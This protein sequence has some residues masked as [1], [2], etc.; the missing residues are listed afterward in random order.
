LVYLS[1]KYRIL[2]INLP[3]NW[4]KNMERKRL[5]DISQGNCLK[6]NSTAAI[7]KFSFVTIAAVL[8]IASPVLALPFKRGNNGPEVLNIQRCLRTLGYFTGQPNGNF[9]PGTE[10]AVIKFQQVEKILPN[11][12]VGP[13]TLG[14]LQRQCKNTSSSNVLRRGSRGAAV[15]KL[16]E[17]LRRLGLNSP[18]TDFF[19][20][21]TEQAVNRF[22]KNQGLPTDGIVD[23]KT[24]QTI[25]TALT[26]NCGRV[27]QYPSLRLSDQGACVKKLQQLL[28]YNEY[29]NRPLTDYFGKE[30]QQAVIKFEQ[31]NELQPDGVA[32]ANVWKALL[33]NIRK[34]D[35][36]RVISFADRG[37]DVKEVQ[38]SLRRMGLF[39]D[40]VNGYY[41]DSTMLAV[42]A[43]QKRQR[44]PES[45]VVDLRTWEALRL[46]GFINKSNPA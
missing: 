36:R 37:D 44:L 8:S 35:G 24:Q 26:G 39:K 28:K 30:T 15:R 7:A 16:Q 13:T 2:I 3:K 19:G 4:K 41:G 42:M 22:K 12:V 43:L 25:Q 38:D 34:P 31:N 5:E 9:G 45:G 11:G 10:A 46:I 6:L 33:A 14:V 20:P 40:A 21:E 18:V 32:D 27:G 29:Y 17:D 23:Q 1:S